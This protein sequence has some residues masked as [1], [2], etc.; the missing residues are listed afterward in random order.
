MPQ[1]PPDGTY[2]KCLVTMG[3]DLVDT[4]RFCTPENLDYSAADIIRTMLGD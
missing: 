2:E 4:G 3:D 1:L